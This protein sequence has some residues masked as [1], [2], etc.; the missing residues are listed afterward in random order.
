VRMMFDIVIVGAGPAGL[1][2]GIYSAFFEM[3]TLI[4]ESDKEAGGRMSV[5]RSIANYPGFPDKVSGRELASKM[6]RQAHQA[7]A[8]LHTSEKVVSLSLGKE[9]CVETNRDIYNSKVLVLAT[10][11]GMKGL[12]L[13]G[14]TWIGDGVS[15]CSQCNESLIREMDTIVIGNTERTVDEAVHLSEIAASVRLVN[16]AEAV[17]IG[18]RKRQ[19]L[20]KNGV[21]LIQGFVGEAIK[22]KPPH[23]QL[24]L[25]S[26]R[27][28]KL[29]KVT[30][31]IIL[32]VSPTVP[33]VSVLQKAGIATHR[34]GCISVD[35]FGR[36][37]I[38]GAF[39]TGS[40]ASMAK[41]IVP[42]CVGDGTA[43]AAHACL[44]VKNEMRL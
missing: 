27:D 32:V 24:V 43:V 37:N 38:K 33:F 9:I 31:N 7:G 12:G 1:A 29:R 26:S 42:S 20:Q 17:R 35:E 25:R 15:Y 21:E 44:Y 5:A 3:Q 2:A 19:Q 34:A 11:A 30:A 22:G 39:A 23:K 14:E 6:A 16:H 4:L 40:C 41:D 10:G 18:V 36:T 28:S 13:Q 8:E